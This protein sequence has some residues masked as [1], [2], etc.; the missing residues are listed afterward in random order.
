MVKAGLRHRQD[1]LGDPYFGFP[2]WRSREDQW[3]ARSAFFVSW[4]PRGIRADVHDV[5][6]TV[7][8]RDADLEMLREM[9]GQGWE[10]GLHASIHARAAAGGLRRSRE[11]LASLLG[12]RID[13]VRHH[14]WAL[15]WEMPWRTLQQHAL[16]GFR[17]DSSIAWRDTA[18]FRAGTSLPYQP[19]DLDEQAALGIWELPTAVMDGHILNSPQREET[20]WRIT[21]MIHEVRRVGGVL[22]LDWH[23]ETA[24][25]VYDRAG[26]M[27]AL[28]RVLSQ[29][30]ATSDAW[31]T[32][33][34]RLLDHW[35][36]RR[37]TS[38]YLVA[39]Q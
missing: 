12:I 23:T 4:R 26:Y 8:N 37:R 18:G 24:T 19:F 22:V 14:Y 25:S 5:R 21:K 27:P 7:R 17:Y 39:L 34:I 35:E 1:S 6:S 2:H 15:D 13:G 33:P 16:A 36:R 29:V 38:G 28:E 31:I 9:A 30:W 10:F 11:E 3:D 32:S 20:E